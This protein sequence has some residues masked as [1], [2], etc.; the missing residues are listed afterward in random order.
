MAQNKKQSLIKLLASVFYLGYLPFM[1]GTFGSLVGLILYLILHRNHIIYNSL[2]IGIFLL[3]L[4]V[5]H[6]AEKAFN[7]KDSQKIVIDELSGMMLTFI[8]IPFTQVSILAGFVL[9]R[10]FD[11]AKP[12]P[13]KWLQNLPKGFSVMMDDLGAAIY[14]NAALRLCAHLLQ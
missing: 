3:G 13:L 9:F 11:I 1:P 5:A 2:T 10:F 7:Q 4:I 14:A 6:P 12:P 8:Y